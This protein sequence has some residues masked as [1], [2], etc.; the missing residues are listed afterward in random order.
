MAENARRR[1]LTISESRLS[2]IL[3]HTFRAEH[4][5]MRGWTG[6]LRLLAE[7]DRALVVEL[8]EPVLERFRVDVGE[9]VLT[10][11]IRI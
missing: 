9:P 1:A 6:L 2:S 3:R 4:A 11:G 7:L 8:D 10:D 5:Q